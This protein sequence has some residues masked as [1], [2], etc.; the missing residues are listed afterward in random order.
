V[1][2][3]VCAVALLLVG[4][5]HVVVDD[6]VHALD[7]DAAADQVGGHQDA[8]LALLEGLVHAEPARIRAA[9]SMQ[10]NAALPPSAPAQ[11]TH[12]ECVRPRPL[13]AFAW[14]AAKSRSTVRLPSMSNSPAARIESGGNV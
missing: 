9:L 3:R 10:R 14:P 2:V 13:C 8:L 12:A 4:L 7:V 11:R 5:G 6:N 1:Q